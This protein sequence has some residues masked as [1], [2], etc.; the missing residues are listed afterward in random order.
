MGW[1]A[2]V[3]ARAEA[4]RQAEEAAAEKRQCLLARFKAG[5]TQRALAKEMGVSQQRISRMVVRARE[6]AA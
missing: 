2:K 6:E 1:R 5:E 3:K 4:R